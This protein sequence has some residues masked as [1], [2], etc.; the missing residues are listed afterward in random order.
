MLVAHA[1]HFGLE[2]LEMPADRA[3]LF[4]QRPV[5]FC[6]FFHILSDLGTPVSDARLQSFDLANF[7]LNIARKILI[8]RS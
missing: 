7:Q 6:A 2:F 8:L 1:I 5:S 4:L 3:F